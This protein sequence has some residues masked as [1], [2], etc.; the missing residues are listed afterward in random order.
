MILGWKK[1][2][3]CNTI[4]NEATCTV[5]Q[6]QCVVVGGR[7]TFE[8]SKKL[9]PNYRKKGNR[10]PIDSDVQKEGTARLWSSMADQ[11]GNGFRTMNKKRKKQTAENRRTEIFKA[12]FTLTEM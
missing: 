8:Y 9:K 10:I 7:I 5:F 2:S 3:N 11:L 1:I 12:R 6:G 4:R